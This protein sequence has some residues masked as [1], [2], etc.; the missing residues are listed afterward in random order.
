MWVAG[1]V[2]G[3]LSTMPTESSPDG[4]WSA[5]E[6]PPSG[7][8]LL[9]ESISKRLALRSNDDQ[10]D[11]LARVNTMST[12]K[13]QSLHG[14]AHKNDLPATRRLS[15]RRHVDKNRTEGTKHEIKGAVKEAAGKVTGNKSKEVAGNMEKN[16]GKVQKEVGKAADDARKSNR[17]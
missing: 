4:E 8:I 13:S 14:S 3:P 5:A 9:C 12:T 1:G 2:I 15:W 11:T 10:P 16:A 7:G 17:K 6:G